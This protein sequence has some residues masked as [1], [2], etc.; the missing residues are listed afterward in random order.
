MNTEII[1]YAYPC[2]MAEKALRDA[3]NSIL[4][5]DYD[6]ALESAMKA[7]VECRMVV[8]SIRDMREQSLLT[9]QLRN[10]Q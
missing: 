7:V 5:R 8:Q 1:D 9:D 2:M 4:K 10:V 3:H 6:A